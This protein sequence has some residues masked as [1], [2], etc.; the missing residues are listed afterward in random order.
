VT[1][2]KLFVKCVVIFIVPDLAQ[3]TVDDV[4]AWLLWT[5]RQYN[6]SMI[7]MEYFNMDGV[8]LSALSEEEFQKRAPEVSF[9]LTI[10]RH[11]N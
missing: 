6:L 8:A 11:L 10:Q 7:H 3:W 9:G 2:C 4:K 1:G 5:L